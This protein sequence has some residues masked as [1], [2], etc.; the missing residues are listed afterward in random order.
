MYETSCPIR[1]VLD[2]IA[3]KWTVL[4]VGA[5]MHDTKRFGVLRKD[6]EGISQKMLTQT[7]RG[8]ER[9]GLINRKAYPTIPP[10]VEYSL[11]ETGKSMIKILLDIKEWSEDNVEYILTS[12][13][14]YDLR[15]TEEINKH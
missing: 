13:K 2:R 1:L 14:T 12:R 15:L 4:I 3:D 6:I 7:L 10:K 5:L 11:T 8:M 9:D